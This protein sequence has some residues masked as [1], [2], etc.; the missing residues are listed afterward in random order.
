MTIT[1]AF[2]LKLLTGVPEMHRSY[3]LKGHLD[4][5]R[6]YS[7]HANNKAKPTILNTIWSYQKEKD[8]E[9]IKKSANQRH[10]TK[11]N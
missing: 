4:C 6:K 5:V 10:Q 9:K 3:Y 1:K 2:Y 8:H 7:L 11:T